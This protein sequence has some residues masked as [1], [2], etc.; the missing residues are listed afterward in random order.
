L[1]A[2]NSRRSTVKYQLMDPVG[3]TEL[4]AKLRTMPDFLMATFGTLS[5]SEATRPGPDNAFSP[6][7]QCWHLVD[8]EREGFALRMRR[9]RAEESPS[10]PDFD[11]SE[12]ARDR[13]YRGRSLS[14][15]LAEFR[16]ARTESLA[17]IESIEAEEWNRSGIQEGVGPVTLCD[18]PVMMSEHDAA[19]RAEIA[20]WLRA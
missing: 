2:Y 6:V 19:H 12:I 4:V 15:G 7:E 5:A 20:A 11:G 3:Q 18:V 1:I 16:Q 8:L 13:N 17:L 9:L 14:E 10:L